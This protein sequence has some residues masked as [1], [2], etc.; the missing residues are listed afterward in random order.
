MKKF[1][2]YVA[3]NEDWYGFEVI[4]MKKFSDYVNEN[5]SEYQKFL[6]ELDDAMFKTIRKLRSSRDTCCTHFQ[7]MFTKLPIDEANKLLDK[8]EKFEEFHP[9]NIKFY[10]KIVN[11]K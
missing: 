6:K 11:K 7:K 8:A 1:S 10:R 4:E 5:N 3:E 2:D 9:D